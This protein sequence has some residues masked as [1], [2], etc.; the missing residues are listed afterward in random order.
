MARIGEPMRR[1]EPVSS[2]A[3][4][5]SV[6]RTNSPG[7]RI[8]VK[9]VLSYFGLTLCALV[10]LTG[11]GSSSGQTGTQSVS[12]TVSDSTTKVNDLNIT[13]KKTTVI[14]VSN[15]GKSVH[16]VSLSRLSVTNL[17]VKDP[18]VNG[19]KVLQ[20]APTAI[21]FGVSIPSGQKREIDFVAT[22]TGRFAL[23]LDGKQVAS[24]IVTA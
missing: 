12:V 10:A 17:Q 14:L 18:Q 9:S 2:S 13:E 16:E 4:V 6:W 8:S 5:N 22:Q 21:S 20:K 15:T 19:G 7:P 11:C 24:V 23:S 3:M 1:G